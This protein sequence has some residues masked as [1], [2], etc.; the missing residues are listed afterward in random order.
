MDQLKDPLE[1][2]LKKWGLKRSIN[3]KMALIIWEE[4]TGK[5]LSL[6]TKAVA[7]KDGILFVQVKNS[8]WAQHLSFLKDTYIKKL[9]FRLQGNIIKEIRFR[10]GPL[11]K[12]LKPKSET[13]LKT[14]LIKYSLSMEEKDKVDK[15]LNNFKGEEIVKKKIYDILVMDF[16]FKK[17]REDA[18]WGKCSHCGNFSSPGKDICF[19]CQI[20]KKER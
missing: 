5:K 9:N 6:F 7:V 17:E 2:I 16:I 18:G 12:E 11:N 1:K 15:I 14:P 4:V 13:S 10:V 20:D 19:I 8:S 3:E